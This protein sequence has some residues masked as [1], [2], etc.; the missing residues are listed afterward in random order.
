MRKT[1]VYLSL[2]LGITMLSITSFTPHIRAENDPCKAVL[3]QGIFNS[4]T[5]V[6]GTQ[7]QTAFENWL[8]TTE[9][10]TYEELRKNGVGLGAIVYGVPVSANW[11]MDNATRNTWKSSHCQQ[12][13][14]TSQYAARYEEVVKFV[15]P[16]IM[17]AW[18]ECIRIV[19]STTP[20]LKCYVTA[21]DTSTAIYSIKYV[22]VDEQDTALPVVQ[23][24]SVTGATPVDTSGL[25]PKQLIKN[26]STIRQSFTVVA[27]QRVDPNKPISI[28]VQTTRGGCPQY[29]PPPTIVY[30]TKVT[31]T[32][33][34][35]MPVSV[36][37]NMH[38]DDG[39]DDCDIN[40]NRTS[41]YTIREGVRITGW[42]TPNVTSSNCPTGKSF[43][44]S[45]S[46]RREGDRTIAIDYH[47]EGC[48]R[49]G[50]FGVAGCAGRGWLVFDM[51]VQ[52]VR[53]VTN[54]L[55]PF[56]ADS[57]ENSIVQTTQ[58]V[59]YPNAVPDGWQNVSWDYTVEVTRRLMLGD[60]ELER[61]VSRL[62]NVNP[63]GDGIQTNIV[64]GRLGIT[65]SPTNIDV[66]S[67][68][69]GKRLIQMRP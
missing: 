49:N 32:P 51:P 48:G 39:S 35:E 63:Q 47:L 1:G 24:S 69:Q 61:R 26:N 45:N 34:G 15:A 20:G 21:P 65:I 38:L 10:S 18:T 52:A 5:I 11:S 13:M 37:E 3:E 55:P 56:S 25:G 30:R 59:D 54:S 17:K 46:V 41:R 22:P 6:A 43:P 42:G 33:R 31:I 4:S 50:P 23:S 62:S 8:C 67:L 60:L 44:M 40:Q 28:V 64:N 12:S 36:T 57:G 27:L 16:E 66:T 68:P 19:Y 58:T 53:Y 2:L 7:S 29:V 9:F 14:G